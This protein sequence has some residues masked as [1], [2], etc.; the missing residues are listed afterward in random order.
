MAGTWDVEVKRSQAT[1]TLRPLERLSA[2][3]RRELTDE[4]ERVARAVHPDAKAHAVAFAG[5]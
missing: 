3:T 4:A 1:V 2:A 5:S